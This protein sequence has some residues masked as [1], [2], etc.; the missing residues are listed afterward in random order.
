MSLD[1]DGKG[2]EK[3]FTRWRV[4][5]SDD[6]DWIRTFGSPVD[7]GGNKM[8][9]AAGWVRY[10][11][12]VAAART[13]EVRWKQGDIGNMAEVLQ[14]AG[15]IAMGRTGGGGDGPRPVPRDKILSELLKFK[16][17]L[18]AV[19]DPHTETKAAQTRIRKLTGATQ[20]LLQEIQSGGAHPDGDDRHRAE[21]WEKKVHKEIGL[22]HK[23]GRKVEIAAFKRRQQHLFE[24][25][26]GKF[27][28]GITGHKKAG[29]GGAAVARNA[30][31][32]RPP[33]EEVL[34]ISGDEYAGWCPGR[35]LRAPIE[36]DW[37]QEVLGEQSWA[38]GSIYA[39]LMNT[40]TA[41]EVDTQLKASGSTAPGP[42]GLTTEA[43]RRAGVTPELTTAFNDIITRREWPEGMLDGIIFPITK[44]L[45]L[46]T[47]DNARPIA[48]LETVLKVFTRILGK[49][50]T[51]ILQRHP[52]LERNQMA[53]VP[54]VDIMENIEVDSFLV[55]VGICIQR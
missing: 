1:R 24:N 50:W 5:A 20:A 27:I 23:A 34:N 46:C 54:G 29:P 19:M 35:V 49:R 53:F 15:D 11:A 26:I 9:W 31:G 37:Y 42:S 13:E 41:E 28:Q 51:A 12:E 7:D 43:W 52:V 33:D 45:G 38:D 30:E 17:A 4:L 2:H 21:E 8:E 25:C 6:G 44:K 40:I 22:R 10:D 16:A 55:S 18:A 32:G 39:H 47:A 36:L 14:N 48:L 3:R